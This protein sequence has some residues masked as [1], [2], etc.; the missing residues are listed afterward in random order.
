MASLEGDVS[1][2]T[3]ADHRLEWTA[4]RVG[5]LVSVAVL[6]AAALGI[7]GDGPL[8]RTEAATPDR[9]VVVDYARFAR[10]SAPTLLKTTVRPR[11]PG[12]P[13]RIG[14][15]R[16]YAESVHVEQVHPEPVRMTAHGDWYEYVFDVAEPTTIVFRTTPDSAGRL[17]GRVR[18]GD[19]AP[20]EFTQLVYP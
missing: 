19:G 8:A 13:V 1:R 7:F 2:A 20:V 14:L 10:A 6:A 4:E 9:R 3:A 16:A 5:W 17:Q 18:V 15:D 11:A 12:D